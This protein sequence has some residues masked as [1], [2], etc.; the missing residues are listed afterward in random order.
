[1]PANWMPISISNRKNS[2][3]RVCSPGRRPGHFR[4]RRPLWFRRP[5]GGSMTIDVDPDWWKTLFDDV[6]LL[7]DARSVGDDHITQAEKSTSSRALISLQTRRPYPRSVRR[8]RP[9]CHRTQPTGIPRLH[10]PGLF[11]A[12]DRHRR[13]KCRRLETARAVCPGG[14]P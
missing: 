4:R 7:T 12:A 9:P 6:Y 1:M 10:R 14:C 8:A 2:K 11:T 13:T 5:S 3:S